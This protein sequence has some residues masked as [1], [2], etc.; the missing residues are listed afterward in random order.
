MP[1][2]PQGWVELGSGQPSA[3]WATGKSQVTELQQGAVREMPASAMVQ[4]MCL[5]GGGEHG[6]TCRQSVHS[7]CRALVLYFIPCSSEHLELTSNLQN[8]AGWVKA[9]RGASGPHRTNGAFPCSQAA[10]PAGP[11]SLGGLRFSSGQ[12]SR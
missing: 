3:C 10:P 6:G 5:L 8:T 9:L 4:K 7:H 12:S 1:S 2:V 11:C